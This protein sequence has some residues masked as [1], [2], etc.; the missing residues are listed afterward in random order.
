MLNEYW[1]RIWTISV[2][3]TTAPY[4]TLSKVIDKI[5]L[6]AALLLSGVFR[7]F[8]AESMT[9]TTPVWHLFIISSYDVFEYE[10]LFLTG[11]GLFDMIS[12]VIELRRPR[13][14]EGNSP[15]SHHLRSHAK[16]YVDLPRFLRA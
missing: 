7:V 3:Q 4:F 1:C 12:R 6:E 8:C 14:D 5:Q 13:P 10:E 15:R 11:R 16:Y 2:C 9:N